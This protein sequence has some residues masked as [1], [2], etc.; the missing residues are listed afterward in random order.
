MDDQ[1]VVESEA[2]D[3]E[4]TVLL[5]LLEECEQSLLEV[6][7]YLGL[8]AGDV[9]NTLFE[10][11][12]GT[13][14]CGEQAHGGSTSLVDELLEVQALLLQ[15]LASEVARKELKTERLPA[16]ST[17]KKRHRPARRRWH[18]RRAM[19]DCFERKSL[20]SHVDRHR[21]ARLYRQV[22]AEQ[23]QLCVHSRLQTVATRRS[24]PAELLPEP[25]PPKRYLEKFHKMPSTSREWPK[26][27]SCNKS[28]EKQKDI[29]VS[30]YL[31]QDRDKM[32]RL[33]ASSSDDLK[34]KICYKF[35]VD[36]I[37]HLM[38]ETALMKP[39]GLY[40]KFVN[41]TSFNQL[42]Q[43]DIICAVQAH[44]YQPKT[45]K[46]SEPSTPVT[47]HEQKACLD[48][49]IHLKECPRQASMSRLPPR[50]DFNGRA[51]LLR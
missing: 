13:L 46:K 44:L 33:V 18:E 32:T 41:V 5:Q 7:R 39:N 24:D 10:L 48:S 12:G 25:K 49:E 45:H 3:E 23:I 27:S 17:S 36:N 8:N 50:W 26:P 43:G 20:Q 4:A 42:R 38:R 35:G 11:D 40:T 37:D 9:K 16:T 28:R 29:L 1:G 2:G 14:V 6:T 47:I 31:N 21:V 19:W 51:M 30:V 34:A 22:K 15:L